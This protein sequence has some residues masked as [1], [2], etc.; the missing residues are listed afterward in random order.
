MGIKGKL[1]SDAGWIGKPDGYNPDT[2]VYSDKTRLAVGT[3]ILWQSPMG[4]INLDFSYP[5][6]KTDYDKK[7]VFLLNFWKG[8]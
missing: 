1:F 7:R 8:F 2:M 3:G 4:M 6:L 5:I